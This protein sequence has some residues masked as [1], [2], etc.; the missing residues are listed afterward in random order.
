MA[1]DPEI[2]AM[3]DVLQALE[4]L[5]EST[6]T[7]VLKWA[8]S[9]YQLED[10]MLVEGSPQKTKLKKGLDESSTG[11]NMRNSVDATSISDFSDLGEFYSQV[12]PNTDSE[13]VL[14]IGVHYQM[15]MGYEDLNS[16]DLNKELKHLGYRVSNVT[17]SISLLM[18]KKPALMIQTRK[19]GNSKQS[20]KKY[21]VTQAGIKYIEQLLNKSNEE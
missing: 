10:I 12:D 3:S 14:T 7:R 2:K 8:I 18:K 20:R 21:R 19:E 4:G 16:A 9:K 5:E 6:R 17:V 13:K 11:G 1:L 15:N